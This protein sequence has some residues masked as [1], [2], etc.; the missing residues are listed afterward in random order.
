MFFGAPST[1]AFASD[2]G[3]VFDINSTTG[4]LAADQLIASAVS[5]NAASTFAFQDLGDGTGVSNGQSFVVIDSASTISGV[6]ANL[7][8]GSTFSSNGVDYLVDYSGGLDGNDL[9]LTATVVPEPAALG[10]LGFVAAALMSR[11]RRRA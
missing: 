8:D 9:T 5:I 7:A 6:F 1:V 10:T 4:S 2:G 3:F 11:R